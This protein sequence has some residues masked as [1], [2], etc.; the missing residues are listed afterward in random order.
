VARRKEPA[1]P[2]ERGVD[3]RVEGD[4]TLAPDQSGEKSNQTKRP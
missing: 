2:V 1:G 4:R 3:E